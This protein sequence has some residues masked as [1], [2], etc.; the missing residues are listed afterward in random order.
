MKFAGFRTGDYKGVIGLPYLV[1]T[2]LV[3]C[4]GALCWFAAWGI[5][6]GPLDAKGD[7]QLGSGDA[8][9]SVAS[10]ESGSHDAGA[11]AC[12]DRARQ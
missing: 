5:G 12:A 2:R 9:K 4:G 1:P 11:C 7:P 6:P 8:V 10:R 3:G